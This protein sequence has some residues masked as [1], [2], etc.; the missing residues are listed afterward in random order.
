M[1][2]PRNI[3]L[4]NT[5][6]RHKVFTFKS[7]SEYQDKLDDGWVFNPADL[8]KPPVKAEPE[9]KVDPKIHK[10]ETPTEPLLKVDEATDE[11]KCDI[12]DFKG[13]S[14]TSLRMHKLHAHKVK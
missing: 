10:P 7:E 12:C 11:L 14:V 3:Q 13:K 1:R 5:G 8:R 6:D 9:E 4:H 2:Y